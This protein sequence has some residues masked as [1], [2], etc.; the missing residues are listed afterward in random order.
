MYRALLDHPADAHGANEWVRRMIPAQR[1]IF[2]TLSPVFAGDDI[3]QRALGRPCWCSPELMRV[4][5][6]VQ[7][8]QTAGET[9]VRL[10][11]KADLLATQQGALSWRLRI[12]TTLAR[13]YLAEDKGSKA[14]SVLAPVYEGFKQG[15]ETR[16]LQLAAE[17]LDEM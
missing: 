12:A 1:D 14:R 11:R 16:D 8:A 2:A 17:L 3:R 10:L 6:E 15:F 13:R 9:D 5:V 7:P 4:A